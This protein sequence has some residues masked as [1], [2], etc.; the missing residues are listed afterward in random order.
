MA[1]RLIDGLPKIRSMSS[2]FFRAY[3]LPPFFGPSDRIEERGQV[4]GGGTLTRVG[5]P[6]GGQAIGTVLPNQN[7]SVNALVELAPAA[8]PPESRCTTWKVQVE[9]A[10]MVPPG[11]G[12]ESIA[13]GV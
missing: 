4:T 8:L 1:T 12:I 3:D 6:S 5:L 11:M 7:V 9:L 13:I 2:V 10:A